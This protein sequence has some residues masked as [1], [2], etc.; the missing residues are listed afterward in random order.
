M[1]QRLLRVVNY[2]L[3]TLFN[4]ILFWFFIGACGPTITMGIIIYICYCLN[5]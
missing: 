3:Y 1:Q 2:I 5:P 4:S